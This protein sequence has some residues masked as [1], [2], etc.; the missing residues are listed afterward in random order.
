MLYWMC[1][2]LT[3]HFTDNI[4]YSGIYNMITNTLGLYSPY[5]LMLCN[6][7]HC[8][9][10]APSLKCNHRSSVLEVLEQRSLPEACTLYV[11]S[12]CHTIG[13]KLSNLHFFEPAFFVAHS[14]SFPPFLADLVFYHLGSAFYFQSIYIWLLQWYEYEIWSCDTAP[15]AFSSVI[16]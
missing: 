10:E 14:C 8:C 5:V 1:M 4:V 12:Y 6:A 9:V 15:S 11:M 16:L 2:H 3:T 7:K 13:A